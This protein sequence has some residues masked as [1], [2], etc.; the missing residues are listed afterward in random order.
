M[1]KII[2][3]ITAVTL[4]AS[5]AFVPHTAAAAASKKETIGVGAGGVI[6]AVAGGP[7]GLIVGAAVGAKI[8]DTLH[9]KDEEITALSTTLA[10]SETTVRSLEYD[11]ATLERNIDAMTSQ[12]EELES[13]SMPELVNLLEAGIAMDLLF[14]T[15]EHVLAS[16]TRLRLAELATAIAAMPELHVRVDGFADERGDEAYNQALSEKRAGFVREQLVAAGVEPSRI[17]TQAH[18]EAVAED[19]APDSLA[20][21]RRVSLT[22]FIAETPSFASNPE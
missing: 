7:V 2:W 10:D 12:L 19:T 1:R 13:A 5:A 17:S 21:E 15:D 16:T 3:T 9:R 22:L 20:L 18:G 4:A 6:G 8:G 11:V 14:R